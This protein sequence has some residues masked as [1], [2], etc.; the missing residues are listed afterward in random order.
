MRKLA[1][2]LFILFLNVFLINSQNET[3]ALRYSR[4][5][6]GG[7]ARYMSMGGSFGALGGEQSAIGFN[8]AGLG[9]FRRSEI[10]LTPTL[11]VETVDAEYLSKKANDIKYNFNFNNI[12]FVGSFGS[13][14]NSSG[15]ENIGFAITYNRINNFS[16]NKL[17]KGV[18]NSNSLLDL[19]MY[20]SDGTHPNNLGDPQFLA[21]DT[22]LIDTIQDSDYTY[23]NELYGKYG[24]TQR[25]T[26]STNGKVGESNFAFGG[27]YEKK[28]YVG[29]SIGIRNV[30]YEEKTIY[31]EVDED[32]KVD[33]KSFEYE[34]SLKTTGIGFNFKFGILFQP[35]DM[36]RIGGSIHTPTFYNL[37]DE[38]YSTM[39]S[40]FDTPD[41]DGKTDYLTESNTLNYDY[42]LTSP[43]KATGSLAIIIKKFGLI[44]LDYEYIDYSTSRLRSNDYSFETENEN[45]KSLYGIAHNLRAG[46]EL[47]FGPIILR[48]GYSY[49]SSPYKTENITDQGVIQ[50]YSGGVGMRT[51]AFFIDIALIYSTSNDEYLLY[52]LENSSQI[53]TLNNVQ[54]KVLVTMGIKF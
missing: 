18:N 39:N 52:E 24:E 23:T 36:I 31:S 44:S 42:N 29:F 25:K 10:T 12:G 13:V 46:A 45:I 37:S 20:N 9:V 35:F 50:S 34:E 22:W 6:H 54:S 17:I 28:V 21:F 49:Y 47:N 26:I 19:Y 4:N 8:P 15:W 53:A 38:F 30:K 40:Y 16:S 14:T 48:G 41:D 43:L 3:D 5:F 32:D 27:R 11:Y 7:T 33:F 1:N 51:S 2:L